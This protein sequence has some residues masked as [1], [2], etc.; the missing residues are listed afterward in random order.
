MC[1]LLFYTKLKSTVIDFLNR[2]SSCVDCLLG[3]GYGSG[4]EIHM[5][6]LFQIFSVCLLG[7]LATLR[8]ATISFVL[9]AC[10]SVCP[11][12]TTRCYASPCLHSLYCDDNTKRIRKASTVC[13][14]FRRSAEVVISRMR[15]FFI[16]W[17]TTDADTKKS[18]IVFTY[19]SVSL[20]CLR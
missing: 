2:K 9:S 1:C 18:M 5:Q 19:C 16:H 11:H 15:A 17:Q 14:Y 10:P 3:T 6:L 12:G 13:E 7:A 8:K 4:T 20:K